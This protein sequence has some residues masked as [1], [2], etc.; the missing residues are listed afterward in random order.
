MS[1]APYWGLVQV[2]M[3]YHVL[4]NFGSFPTF[5][6]IYHFLVPLCYSL[7]TVSNE[8]L[9]LYDESQF[10]APSREGSIGD[11]NHG[12]SLSSFIQHLLGVFDREIIPLIMVWKEETLLIF[13]ETKFNP[14]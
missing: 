8:D 12:N 7:S 6:E 1:V 2:P 4:Q 13:A 9:V 5:K 11:S 14:L 3:G 10:T